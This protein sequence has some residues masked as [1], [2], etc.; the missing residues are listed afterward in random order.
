MTNTFFEEQLEI[1]RSNMKEL[2]FFSA[3][4]DEQHSR[5][6]R[7]FGAAPYCT[8]TIMNEE[9]MIFVMTNIDDVALSLST[10]LTKAGKPVKSK[11][12]AAHCAAMQEVVDIFEDSETSLQ[13]FVVD[14]SADGAADAEAYFKPVWKD[15]VTSYDLWHKVK[16][17]DPLL[18]AH[19]CQREVKRGAFKHKELNFLY[20]NGRFYLFFLFIIMI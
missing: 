14:Q 17:F 2:L 11:A 20:D 10:V 6:Q 7:S 19:C 5:S 13:H 1:V 16:Q 9:S 4:M 8:C 12:K 18:K 3:G 15:Y